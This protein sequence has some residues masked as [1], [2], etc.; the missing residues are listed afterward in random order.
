MSH[1]HVLCKSILNCRFGHPYI[2]TPRRV[3]KLRTQMKKEMRIGRYSI[4]RH[5][6]KREGKLHTH[7]IDSIPTSPKA[8]IS[9][10]KNASG[11][12]PPKGVLVVSAS[13]A[14]KIQLTIKQCLDESEL[15]TDFLH[16]PSQPVSG[17]SSPG[18]DRPTFM[19]GGL[20]SYH[21]DTYQRIAMGTNLIIII[22]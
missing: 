2:Y 14:A 7:C 22:S 6:R 3:R 17:S 16:Q 18:E 8:G 4:G 19:D 11:N 12:K 1:I 21:S 20:Y 15:E 10:Y 5:A 13:A 9:H